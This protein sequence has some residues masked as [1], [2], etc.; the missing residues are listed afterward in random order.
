MFLKLRIIHRKILLLV[1]LFN[2]VVGPKTWNLIK[3]RLQHWCFPV[4][5]ALFFKKL[6]LQN[7]FGWLLLLIPPFQ[8]RFYSLITL[9]SFFRSFFSFYYW[10]LQL[11]EFV[12]SEQW[13][14]VE[15]WIL[16]V[17][18]TINY[19]QINMNV[20]LIKLLLWL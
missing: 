1:S 14:W 9:F 15:K 8:S 19:P 7:T 11:W 4:N 6:Y 16:F 13:I 3:K 17:L 10:S 20:I 2:K 18:F 12:L 5:F